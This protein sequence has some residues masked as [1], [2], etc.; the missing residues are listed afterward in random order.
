[1]NIALEDMNE[2]KFK[3]L[4][5]RSHDIVIESVRF[6]PRERA[7]TI[8]LMYCTGMA[9]SSH[10][11]KVVL[12]GLLA[13]MEQAETV[14][15][16]ILGTNNSLLL[17][18]VDET[19]WY[20]PFLLRLYTG[21]LVLFIES[22][23]LL[24]TANTSMPPNRQP[25]E[26]S[27]EVS[28]K[29]PRDAFTEDLKTN[30]ALVRKRLLT[31]SL[32]C[33][34]VTVGKR[35]HTSVALL[36]IDDI[37]NPDLVQNARSK[38]DRVDIDGL[39]SSG[40][41]EEG[42][43]DKG[44]S[45]FPLL[46]YI[47]RPDFIVDSLLR[48][49]ISLI[50]DGSPM[51]LV[52][53]ANLTLILKSPEDVHF[54]SYYV[55]IER[56]LRLIGL[57]LAICFP[58]FYIAITSYN[59]DQIPFPLLATIASVRIGLPL[60]GPMDFFLMLGLFELLREAGVRLPKPVGQTVAVVGGLIVG[61]AAIRAGITSPATLVA[62]AISTMAMYTLVNQS[63]AGTVTLLRI[64]ILI[65]SAAFGIFGFI[66]SLMALA[67]YLS[68]L[69]SFGV[70]YMAPISPPSLRDIYTAVKYKVSKVAKHRPAFLEPTD[71]TRRKGGPS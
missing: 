60:S 1:M 3:E 27:T 59:F 40:Q 45:L 46:E 15:P 36:Y 69:E 56:V 32:C 6:G 28:V 63:L 23:G 19:D 71:D 38:L 18:R 30:V 47:G 10:I 52:A 42:L 24:Y 43:T 33:E 50:V 4:F 31:H 49:R 17:R 53:P 16:E 22:A 44:F 55:A 35:S 58:G 9:E 26:S 54:P 14:T 5:A 2:H 64:M 39:I 20:E 13:V 67:L 11:S 61:D 48:G 37:A 34:I 57:T 51:A 21:D 66:V 65:V 7:H 29:G 8:V 25:E 68:T 12:P 70:P 41:L 62:V